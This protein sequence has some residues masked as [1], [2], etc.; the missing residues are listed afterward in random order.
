VR[1]L[2][3]G[4]YTVKRVRVLADIEAVNRRHRQL[5]AGEVAR[6]HAAWFA[7]HGDCYRPRTVAIIREGQQVG[8][9][10][11]EQARDGRLALR[12]VLET[13]LREHGLDAWIC[14]AAPGPAPE[15]IQTTGD[16]IMNLPWTH[17]GLPALNL[18]AGRDGRGLPLGLQCVA[19]FMRDEALLTWGE[20]LA[21]ELE[22]L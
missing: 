5:I 3:E 8:D 14:P 19:G 15:G 20:G 4:G 21:R 11:L 13:G 16:P 18:P 12:E 9:R 10:E 7:A 1:C 6:V 17:A 22:C 2:E